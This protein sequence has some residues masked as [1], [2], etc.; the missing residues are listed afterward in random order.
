[1]EQILLY[2]AVFIAAL[3]I[4]RIFT[5][6]IRWIFRLLLNTGIGFLGLF[7]LSFAGSFLGITLGINLI[8]A[9]VVGALGLPGLILLLLLRWL[10]D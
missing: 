4:L 8:N 6:P 5:L 3:I 7:L 10:Y 1:M 9:V 2:A